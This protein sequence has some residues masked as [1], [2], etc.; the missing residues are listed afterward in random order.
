MFLGLFHSQATHPSLSLLY[1]SLRPQL[2]MPL[3]PVPIIQLLQTPIGYCPE[4]ILTKPT[5]LASKGDNLRFVV[6]LVPDAY[7]VAV[8]VVHDTK[9]GRGVL[10]LCLVGAFYYG[11]ASTH[12]GL[13]LGG[14]I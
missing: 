11:A 6:P 12:G 3:L 13:S 14:H 9:A 1:L 5:S 7:S 4:L 10:L 8:L 2:H